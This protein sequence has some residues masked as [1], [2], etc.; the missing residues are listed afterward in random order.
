MRINK[1]ISTCG[2]CSRREA[3]ELIK[4]GKVVVNGAVVKEFGIQIQ[5]TDEVCVNGKKISATDS[6]VYIMLNK[7]QG[8]VTTSKE[9]FNRPCVMD[10]INEDV[11]VFPVGRLDMYSEGLLILTNDGELMNKIIHPSTHVPKTY[12][13]T[14]NSELTL[15]HINQLESGVDIGGYITQKATI[16]NVKNNSFE[17]T[18]CEGKNRQIRKMCIAVGLKVVSLKRIKIGKLE[19]GSLKSGKYRYLTFEDLNKITKTS[20]DN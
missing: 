20:I 19:L 6:K 13:V 4:C 15:E 12:R 9:Q 2:V 11:R 7:P 16:C 10:L 1:Y 18:I 3:D 5:D 8:Y 17:I 14:T